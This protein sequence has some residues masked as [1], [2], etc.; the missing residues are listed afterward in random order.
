MVISIAWVDLIT[1]CVSNVRLVTFRSFH[2]IMF[3]DYLR[4]S[5]HLSSS[6]SSTSSSAM[7]DNDR[8]M[9]EQEVQRFVITFKKRIDQLD[10]TTKDREQKES[11]EI[12]QELDEA[13]PSDETANE[14]LLEK[15]SLK[16]QQI[17]SCRDS[18]IANLSDLLQNCLKMMQEW[19]QTRTQQMQED[20]DRYV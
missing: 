15:Y 17:R 1:R 19:K 7:S 9:L 5:R 12:L 4:I 8:D 11:E 10:Q 18:I 20:V 16:Q 2:S 6:N 13:D 3:S 14:E